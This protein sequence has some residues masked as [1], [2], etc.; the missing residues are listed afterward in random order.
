[1]KPT[2]YLALYANHIE[3]LSQGPVAPSTAVNFG[4]ALA[5]MKSTQNEV[6]A[7]LDFGR[8]GAGLA[9]FE[10]E[11][12][13]SRINAANTFVADGEQR[14]RGI[15]INSYGE[16]RPGWR[17]LGGAA[18][19]DAQLSNTQDGVNNGKTARGVPK[20]QYNLGTEVDIKTVAG[21]TVTG[22]WIHTGSQFVNEANN[23]SIPSW[24]R[25]DL[26]AR[27]ATKFKQG[28]LTLRAS[29]ENILDKDY[30]SAVTPTFG[31]VTLGAPRVFRL[32]ATYDF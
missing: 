28:Q 18:F 6:G 7:K 21:L 12:P 14:N 26:G 2:Q 24:D 5:P 11:R 31:Q 19:T 15:E 8:F 16:I 25:F 4:Q 23:M 9:L 27:Y 29:L 3:G 17:V 22:R 1:V 10:I 13:S 32:S 30:W 20:N